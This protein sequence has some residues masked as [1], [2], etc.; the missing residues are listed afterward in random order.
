MSCCKYK[1]GDL[2][3]PVTFQAKTFTPDG[4]GGSVVS[5]SNVIATLAKIEPISAREAYL[6]DR[7]QSEVTHKIIVRYS[8][9]INNELRIVF[10]GK[11]LEIEGVLNLEERNRWLEITAKLGVKT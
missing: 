5:W 9:L 3:H 1:A 8:S 6:Y 10:G 2:I 11:V 4:M 7:R